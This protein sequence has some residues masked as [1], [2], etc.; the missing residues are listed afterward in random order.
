MKDKENKTKTVESEPRY[1]VDGRVISE[2]EHRANMTR[3]AFSTVM[4][5]A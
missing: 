2:F 1:R 3:I 4:V 5:R